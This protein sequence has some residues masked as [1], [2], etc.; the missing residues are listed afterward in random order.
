M[1]I[2][3]I[4]KNAQDLPAS[5]AVVEGE[6]MAE[7]ITNIFNALNR[8]GVSVAVWN[9]AEN[10]LAPARRETLSRIFH[11]AP[12]RMINAHCT[13][14]N[15]K[16]LTAPLMENL[17]KSFPDAYPDED[18]ALSALAATSTALL[19]AIDAAYGVRDALATFSAE[20]LLPAPDFHFDPCGRSEAVFLRTLDGAA[21]LFAE[22]GDIASRNAIHPRMKDGLSTLWTVRPFALAAIAAPSERQACAHSAPY[23]PV[24]GA[25]NDRRAVEVLQVFTQK[26]FLSP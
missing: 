17:G 15:P 2:R 6:T 4:E 24:S 23:T 10:L 3:L 16:G 11:A 14:R 18:A 12:R 8:P 20:S 7:G 1:K 21:T 5:F 26:P 19:S 13:R 25:R 22:D 9:G